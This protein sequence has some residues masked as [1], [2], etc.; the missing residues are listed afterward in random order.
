MLLCARHGHEV[1]ISYRKDYTSAARMPHHIPATPTAPTTTCSHIHVAH[2]SAG[3]GL[4][5]VAL[6]NLLPSDTEVD[7]LDSYMYQTVC[8]CTCTC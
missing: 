6:A 3:R 4:Q 8:S 1:R 5:V 7:E 2:L